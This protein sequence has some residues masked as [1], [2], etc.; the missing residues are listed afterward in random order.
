[1]HFYSWCFRKHA[2]PDENP[3]EAAFFFFVKAPLYRFLGSSI[4]DL[5]GY[6]VNVN[7][8]SRCIDIPRPLTNGLRIGLYSISK[9]NVD[10]KRVPVYVEKY[11]LKLLLF[12]YY[13]TILSGAVYYTQKAYTGG[14]TLEFE[15]EP[16]IIQIFFY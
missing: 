1:M 4:Q 11:F 3:P 13:K 7:N 10:L 16:H 9:A 14:I 2:D 5:K 15:F 6:N 12:R 8:I